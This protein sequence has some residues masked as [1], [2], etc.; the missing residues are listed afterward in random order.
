[1]L[2]LKI[3]LLHSIYLFIYLVC[4][5]V[6]GWGWHTCYR[7]HVE[8]RGQLNY[9]VF[10]S[11]FAMYVLGIKFRSSGL[12]GSALNT[13]PFHWSNPYI[14][15]H[16][17]LDV[18]CIFLV[19]QAEMANPRVIHEYIQKMREMGSLINVE[20]HFHSSNY[21]STYQE[22]LVFNFGG[23]SFLFFKNCIFSF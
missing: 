11:P 13:K 19:V 16:R 3:Y 5:C 9:Q 18:I 15:M 22:I 8:V 20:T 10:L 23:A 17:A 2:F 7:T 14:S 6:M 12:T 21:F 4:A 1:M